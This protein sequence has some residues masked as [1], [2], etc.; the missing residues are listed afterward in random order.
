MPAWDSEMEVCLI[1]ISD[2]GKGRLFLCCKD[3]Q[4]DSVA[5]LAIKER[6]KL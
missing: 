5:R 6:G 4:C 1:L 3:I 2:L